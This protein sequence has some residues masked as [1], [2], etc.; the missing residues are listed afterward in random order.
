[1]PM[2]PQFGPICAHDALE[3]MIRP[4]LSR[5]SYSVMISI[6]VMIALVTLLGITGA[7]LTYRYSVFALVPVTFFVLVLAIAG[8]VIYGSS[9]SASTLAVVCGVTCLHFGYFLRLFVS[10][11]RQRPAST[12]SGLERAH[13]DVQ[14]QRPSGGQRQDVRPPVPSEVDS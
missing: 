3:R 9:F 5:W 2:A 14:P 4:E 7:L 12:S 1:M 10:Q 13:Q 6:V 11:S 8:C